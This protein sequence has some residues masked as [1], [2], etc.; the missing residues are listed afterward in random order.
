MISR[1][2]RVLHLLPQQANA[3]RQ[4]AADALG[5]GEKVRLNAKLFVGC[6]LYTSKNGNYVVLD[7]QLFHYR[8]NARWAE[9]YQFI[10][11]LIYGA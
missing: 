3:D 7:H 11:D 5:G 6:L 8:P 1:P 10:G 2:Q 4:A 9:A